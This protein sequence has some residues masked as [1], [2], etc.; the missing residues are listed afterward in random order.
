M[1]KVVRSI[2][3]FITALFTITN[4]FNKYLQRVAPCCTAYY[5]LLVTSNLE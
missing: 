4:T 5:R 1:K 3:L 2:E